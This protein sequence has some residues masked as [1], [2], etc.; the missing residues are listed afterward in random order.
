M[1]KTAIIVGA[2]IGGL[3]TA[4]RLARD[5]WKVKVLEKKVR[6]G[7]KLEGYGEQGFLWDIGPSVVRMPFVLREL[8]EY[9]GHDIEDYIELV[10]LDPACR[11]F[12]QDG[13]T[14]NTWANFHHFQI[15]VARR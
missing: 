5:G 15:E 7:G 11:Y 12:F 1:S 4:I 3:A 8:F 13:K 10:P 6:V 9:A 2:G 14:I